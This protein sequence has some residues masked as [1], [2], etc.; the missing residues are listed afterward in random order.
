[1]LRKAASRYY[2]RSLLDLISRFAAGGRVPAMLMPGERLFQPGTVSRLGPGFFDALNQ[3]RLPREQILA[4]LG[5][6][7][8]PVARF[9]AG[10]AVGAMP[11]PASGAGAGRDSVD[12]NLRVNDGTPIRLQGPRDQAQALAGALRALQRQR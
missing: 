6:M 4:A 9:A 1:M 2:G 11:A 8:A 5:N 3:M 10:G 12:I 7:T